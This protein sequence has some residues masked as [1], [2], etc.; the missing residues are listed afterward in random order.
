[1]EDEIDLRK[2]IL[3]LV[4]NWVWIVGVPLLL[5]I[6]AF[7]V[8][9]FVITPEYQ[10]HAILFIVQPQYSLTFDTRFTTQN[11]TDLAYYGSVDDLA[12]ADAL[13]QEVHT[14]WTEGGNPHLT[15]SQVKGMLSVGDSS[16]VNTIELI[17]IAKDPETAA[18][19]VNI[20]ADV[21]VRKTEDVYSNKTSESVTL[22]DQ[23]E[24]ATAERDAA[25]QALVEFQQENTILT[26]Q[27]E[28]TVTQN[29]Y[30]QYLTTQA[31]ISQGVQ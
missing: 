28:L 21:V 31:E 14:I 25:E 30:T 15:Y 16:A 22:Q 13:I 10:A 11:K 26:T 27:A 8:N 7:V 5:A 9:K 17:A 29:I 23:F 2:Y 19:L 12:E 6:A 18:K 1:M 20:W 4:K 3:L 24:Q